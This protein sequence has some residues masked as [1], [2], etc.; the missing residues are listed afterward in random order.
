MIINIFGE[1]IE[2]PRRNRKLESGALVEVTKALETHASVAWVR[3]MNTGAAKIGGRFVRFGWP[4]CPDLIG[5]L[6]DGRFLGVEVKGPDGRLRTDQK[7]FIGI[8]ASH[9]G[10]AF[11]ARNCSDVFENLGSTL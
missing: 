9:G 8:I 6:T 3:R 11:V 7:I 10:V 5:Q 2:L 4:G 1:E